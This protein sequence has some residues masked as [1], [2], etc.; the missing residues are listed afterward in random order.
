MPVY[1]N[2]DLNKIFTPAAVR[3]AIGRLPEIPSPLFDAVFADR[4]AYPHAAIPV[5]D[6]VHVVQ[7]IP[8]VRRG[9]QALPL[10]G[11]SGSVSIIAPDPI[12]VTSFLDAKDIND[13][14]Y[15]GGKNTQALL[16]ETVDKLRRVIVKTTRAL[17]YSALTGTIAYHAS[18]GFGTLEP[19]TIEYGTIKDYKVA[20]SKRWAQ[21]AGTIADILSDLIAMSQKVQESGYGA[22]ITFFVGAKVFQELAKQATSLN[23]ASPI[24]ASV[25]A[26]AIRIAGFE[27]IYSGDS[28]IDLSSDTAKN[29]IGE[30]EVLAIATDAP[31]RIRYLA[32]D[33]LDAGLQALPF[34]V[35]TKK[36]D[37]PS[38]YDVIAHSK[39]LPIVVPSAICKAVV[40]A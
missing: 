32:I 15:M 20:S 30:K 28:S 39:P 16:D 11:Q 5:S 37:N 35:K 12:S 3:Q 17:A 36:K 25:N 19:Y 27:L 33:D 22:T 13:L 38:G 31:H 40:L 21:G 1:N 23:D 4:A 18:G 14:R 7:N 6:I 9:T 2:I 29:A 10:T 34:F 8:L 24:R 26:N